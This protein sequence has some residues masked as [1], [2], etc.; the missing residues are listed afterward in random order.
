MEYVSSRGVRSAVAVA[1]SRKRTIP[2]LEVPSIG[3]DPNTARACLALEETPISW[4]AFVPL[5]KEPERGRARLPVEETQTPPGHAFRWKR[6]PISWRAFVP[7]EKEPERVRACLP[8]EETQTS[9]TLVRCEPNTPKVSPALG[10]VEGHLRRRSIP[11]V[12]ASLPEQKGG[13]GSL[14][15]DNIGYLGER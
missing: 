8:L 3:R 14:T 6:P 1:Q 5:E 2:R 10:A 12:M 15:K 9:D 7:L 13:Q 11:S 4:R